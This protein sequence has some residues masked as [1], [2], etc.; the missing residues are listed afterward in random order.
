MDAFNQHRRYRFSPSASQMF[1]HVHAELS[2]GPSPALIQSIARLSH[3]FTK[4]RGGIGA[5]YLDDATLAAGYASYFLPVNF[6]KV[7]TLLDELPDD[8]AVGE[9][10]LSVLDVGSGPGTASLA[11]LD[12]LLCQN[13]DAPRRLTVTAI[14]HSK[15][16]LMEAVRLW[17]EYRRM[18]PAGQASVRTSV[19]QVEDI[20]RQ[21]AVAAVPAGVPFDL[22]IVAN[23]LNELFDDSSEP[24]EP[25]AAVLER[26]LSMLKADGTLMVLEPALRSTAR[27]LHQTRDQLLSHNLCTVYSPCLHEQGCPALAKVNDWCHEERCWDPPFW[28]TEID[29][30]LKFFYLLL[31]KDGR[32]IVARG[33]QTYRVVSELRIFKGEKRAWLCNEHGRSEV[34]RVDRK[35]TSSNAAFDACHRGALVQIDR[36]VRKEREGRLSEL[37]R[38]A[39]DSTVKILRKV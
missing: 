9:T 22:I 36:F 10:P 12:W 28:I 14:D 19:E 15:A 32:T 39:E 2:G 29:H 24:H 38:I 37:R 7:Q 4:E 13:R 8:W 33:P 31:R 18:N 21:N 25:R 1:E 5:R 3:L 11:V 23:C 30:A 6:C 17:N 16:A 26:F 34:G 27:A 20:I 35:A